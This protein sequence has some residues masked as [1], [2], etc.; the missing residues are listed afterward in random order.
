MKKITLL[1]DYRGFFES[2]YTAVPYNSGMDKVLVINY[3]GQLGWKIEFL[4]FSEIDFREGN[5]KDEIFLYTSSED[6]GYYYKAYIEDV[7]LGLSLMGARVLPDFKFLRSNSNKVFMEILRD[8]L[9]GEEIKNISSWHFGAMEELKRK[10]NLPNQPYVLKPSIG[11]MSEGVGLAKNRDE[12]IKKVKKISRTRNLFREMWELGRDFKYPH[13][14]RESRFREKFIIQNFIPNL[15][16]DWKILIYG[17]KYYILF[18]ENRKNDFRASGGGRL[19]FKEQIPN[20][21]LDFAK[22]VYNILSVPNL[23]IDVA[24]DG[25][26][27]YLLE[28]QA[29][30][31]GTY[32]LEFSPFYFTDDNNTWAL[33]REKSVLEKVYAESVV[34]YINCTFNI[35]I[36][37]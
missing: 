28:F 4:E 29:L 11:A 9:P 15:K 13:Y 17:H 16:N 26:K 34:N 18:R 25:G 19:S 32:T 21:I 20:G 22:N 5:Y 12:L 27:F 35:Q 7:I 1:T 2:K 24:F 30:Y 36:K 23:S 37:N 8:I 3:F 6:T 14:V 31:F 33:K 10:A